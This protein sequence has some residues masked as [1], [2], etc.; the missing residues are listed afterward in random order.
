MEL[1][2]LMSDDILILEKKLKDFIT[3]FDNNKYK[4]QNFTIDIE[5]KENFYD[6]LGWFEVC[7]KKL[8][9][10]TKLDEEK[11]SAI[12]YANNM[13]KHS[14]SIF[15]HTLETL[16]LYP[17]SDLFPSETLYPSD[18]NIFW[19]TLPLDNQRFVNQYNNY[20]KHL[21]GKEILP[22]LNEIFTIIK[23]YY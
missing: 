12:K 8:D 17:S 6:L 22:T 16:A 21:E 7:I 4:N 13:K 9:N 1:E 23:K 18:F 3:L 14:N 11:I 5:L 2:A 10:L 19:N 20:L 15:R